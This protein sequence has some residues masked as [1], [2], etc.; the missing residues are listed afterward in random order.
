MSRHEREAKLEALHGGPDGLVLIT[1]RGGR[2]RDAR[3]A[4]QG[5]MSKLSKM[6]ATT[7]NPA[8]DVHQPSD[9]PMMGSYQ[10]GTLGAL[11][12]KW[13]ESRAE[14]ER[15]RKIWEEFELMADTG[16]RSLEPPE[17]PAWRQPKKY[18]QADWPPQPSRMS[19]DDL[20]AW[21]QLLDKQRERPRPP[22]KYLNGRPWPPKKSKR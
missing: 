18:I 8:S 11:K 22:Q 20:G 7:P 2:K 3:K 21:L 1:E 17:A 14:Q 5:R 12:A 19:S 13:D 6:M 15:L 16:Y 10:A 9:A 4:L